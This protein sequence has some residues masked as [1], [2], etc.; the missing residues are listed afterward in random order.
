MEV[1][2]CVNLVDNQYERETKLPLIAASAK[3]VSELPNGTEELER[4]PLPQVSPAQ[5]HMHL[6]Q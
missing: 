3:N 1:T 4:P 6:Q 2:V 5:K